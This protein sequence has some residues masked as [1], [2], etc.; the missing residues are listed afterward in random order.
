MSTSQSNPETADRS[1]TESAPSHLV[2]LGLVRS[3][4]S[5]YLPRSLYWPLARRYAARHAVAIEGYETPVRPYAIHWVD[6][7]E[8]VRPTGRPYPPWVNRFGQCGSVVAG[9]WD[10][11]PAPVDEDEHPSA[12]LYHAPRL[13]ETVL[14]RSLESHFVDGVPWVDTELVEVASEIVADGDSVWHDCESRADLLDRCDRLDD[15]WARLAGGEFRSQLDL[16]AAGETDHRVFDD[17]IRNEIAV[18]IGRDG[19]LLL[20]DGKH[21]HAMATLLGVDEIPVVVYARHPEW[22]VRRDAAAA[23]AVADDHPALR[24]LPGAHP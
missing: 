23:G 21:R 12:R 5:P 18:D 19:D 10:R 1:P 20:V 6:P 16:A 14:Y 17:A 3:R 13:D 9:D 11:R 2:M 15:L 4:A 22:M 7:T 8:I 24:D